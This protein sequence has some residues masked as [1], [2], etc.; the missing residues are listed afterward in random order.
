[1]YE[2]KKLVITA[3]SVILSNLVFA[4]ND[5]TWRLMSALSSGPAWSDP[6]RTQTIIL[7]PELSETFA[8]NSTTE[9]FGDGEIFFGLQHPLAHHLQVQLGVAGVGTTAIPL[10]GDVWQDADP[11]FN[12]LSYEYKISHAHVAVKGKL[13]TDGY[14]WVQPYISALHRTKITR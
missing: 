6:G 7:Q 12:N 3:C 1:M 8:A 11:N 13:L 9:L 5:G 10:S 2:Y 14:Q 4:G